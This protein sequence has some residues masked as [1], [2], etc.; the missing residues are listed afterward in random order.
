MA[1]EQNLIENTGEVVGEASEVIAEQGLIVADKTQEYISIAIE[2]ATEYGLKIIG[3]LLI[4]LIGK[5]VAVRIQSIVVKLM[6]K[7]KV[8][9]TLVSFIESIVY[10]LLMMLIIIAAISTLGVQTT[11]FVA[12]LGAAGLAIGLALQG[13]LGNVG[14][15]VLL[16][17]FRPFKVGDY[18]EIAGETGTVSGITIFA[19][20]LNTL[21]NKQVIVPNSSVSAGN[22]TNF[23]T[24]TERRIDL[25]FGIGYGDDLK[26]AKE[27]LY[28]IMNDDPRVLD[29]PAPFVGVS[30]LGD[31]S[32][33]FVFRPWVKSDD[34][35]D[36]YFDMNEK[37]KLT[38]DEKGI[39]IPFPQMDI[40]LNKIEE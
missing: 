24:R 34:Y 31:S 10:F 33:N 25:S 11:S 38:F 19:T 1:T 37:V 9:E 26:L 16:I 39:S 36:V 13:T 27:I 40:H 18:V 17:S 32:V 22:I 3:A 2:Y 20:T 23:S 30:E 21:D 4:F 15:G 28:G 12:I 8:D 29:E 35:W 7:N 14:S 5:W 6:H